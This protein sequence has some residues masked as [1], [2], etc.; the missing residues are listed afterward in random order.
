MPHM[1][2]N[3][4]R[5]HDLTKDRSCAMRSAAKR[6]FRGRALIKR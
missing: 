1:F 5:I 4:P 3:R 6:E 2:T